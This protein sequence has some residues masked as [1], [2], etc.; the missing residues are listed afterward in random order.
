MF[1]DNEV[2]IFRCSGSTSRYVI[3][4]LRNTIHRKE[5]K[6][7]RY[8]SDTGSW[9]STLLS[10]HAP[11]RDEVLPIPHPPHGYRAHLPP[12]HQGLPLAG[13]ISGEA[14]CTATCSMRNP[15][16]VIYGEIAVVTLPGQQH[17]SEIKYVEMETRPGEDLPPS[18]QY[19]SDDS[20][21]DDDAECDLDVNPY[22]NATIWTMPVP[23]ASWKDWHKDKDCKVDV[24]DIVVDNPSHSEL[25][26]R[27]PRLSTDPESATMS[28]RR[29][30]TAHPT[31]ELDAN[32]DLV[33]Y[34]LSKV[35][36]KDHKG[37]VIDVGARDKKLQGIAELDSRKNDFF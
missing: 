35:D 1:Q 15:C 33:I 17:R 22:W 12:D 21:S 27:L 19:T 14:S 11:E 28:L 7:Q 31:L 13:S 34:L 9:T 3:A 30:L 32:G 2:A 5:F 36:Y 37:W 6:L 26:L 16:S 4:G 23:V 29:L 25:L 20:G 24:T 18:R 8:D 10:V